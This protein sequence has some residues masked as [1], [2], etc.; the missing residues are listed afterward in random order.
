MFLYLGWVSFAP[1]CFKRLKKKQ[2]KKLKKKKKNRSVFKDF[3]IKH[4]NL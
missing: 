4:Q 1:L 2:Q 3:C